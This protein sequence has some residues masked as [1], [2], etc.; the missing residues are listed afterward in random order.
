MYRF[1]DAEELVERLNGPGTRKPV[2]G[3]DGWSSLGVGVRFSNRFHLRCKSRCRWRGYL[4]EFGTSNLPF[5]NAA[6]QRLFRY[7]RLFSKP[8]AVLTIFFWTAISMNI[9]KRCNHFRLIV[10]CMLSGASR[11]R[12]VIV[13]WSTAHRGRVINESLG[14]LP[15]KLA[16]SPRVLARS[17]SSR[18]QAGTK[19]GGPPHDRWAKLGQCRY[20]RSQHPFVVIALFSNA[21]PRGASIFFS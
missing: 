19:Q 11:D 15:K 17:E 16:P 12:P 7:F 4:R 6:S 18:T 10:A 21:M 2:R 1:L 14:Q 3:P 8:I 13:G 9:E 20:T 5:R